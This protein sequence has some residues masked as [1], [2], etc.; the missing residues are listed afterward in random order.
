MPNR[1]PKASEL[2][3]LFALKVCVVE[4]LDF[5]SGGGPTA[6]INGVSF[7]VHSF[8]NI[9]T[10]ARWISTINSLL[11]R[12]FQ[13]GSN[14]SFG[15]AISCVVVEILRLKGS[16]E[17]LHRIGRKTVRFVALGEVVLWYKFGG[18]TPGSY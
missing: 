18:E 6:G 1:V 14:E 17:R 16:R 2:I 4:T 12:A 9:S 8:V 5:G 15:V 3:K 11:V 10:T 13:C 7:S